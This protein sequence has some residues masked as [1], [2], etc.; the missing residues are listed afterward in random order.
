MGYPLGLGTDGY[1]SPLSLESKASSGYLTLSRF[2]T[3]T[4]C[5]FFMLQ[6]PSIGG[7]SGGPVYDISIYQMGGFMSTGSGTILHGFIHGTIGDN[8][9]GK[10][11][12]VTPAFYFHDVNPA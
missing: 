12:A 6:D 11:A 7:Y 8:T 9:G 2:D 4:T 1:M 3:Q 10:L 5:T